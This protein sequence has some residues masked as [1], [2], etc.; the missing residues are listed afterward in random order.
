[1]KPDLLKQVAG[2][3]CLLSH[4]LLTPEV[5]PYIN[6]FNK[7]SNN[8]NPLTDQHHSPQGGTPQQFNKKAANRINKDFD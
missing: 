3:I 2:Q 6:F 1:M 5:E 7:Y 8:Q 4:S